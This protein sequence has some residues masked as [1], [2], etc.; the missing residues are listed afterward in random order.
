MVCLANVLLKRIGLMLL[1]IPILVLAAFAVGEVAGG[2]ISGLQ[3]VPELALLVLLGW[4]AWRRPLWGGAALIALSL[5]CAGLYI[6]FF[7]SGFPLQTV[8]VTVA[9]LF[10]PPLAAGALFVAASRRPV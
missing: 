5:I 10:A 2:D 9:L 1:A 6:F 3:H 7:A 4:L 8:V